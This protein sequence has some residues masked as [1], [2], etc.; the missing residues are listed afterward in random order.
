MFWK[1][2]GRVNDLSLVAQASLIHISYEAIYALDYGLTS[3][4]NTVSSPDSDGYFESSVMSQV[5][6]GGQ[7]IP[8]SSK[9]P[10]GPSKQASELPY[11]S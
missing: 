4:N 9:S 7:D 11:S 10:S 2:E 6:Q 5:A 1:T 8:P 3:L